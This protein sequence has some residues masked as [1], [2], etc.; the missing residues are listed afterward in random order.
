[1]YDTSPQT[2]VPISDYAIIVNDDD[3]V[4]VVKNETTAGLALVLPNGDPLVLREA[5]PPGHRFATREIR[6]VNSSAS[7]ASRSEPRK[8]SRQVNGSL[9]TT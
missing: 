7:T 6:P 4:A 5:V 9:T 2:E 1:M 8:V 3:N